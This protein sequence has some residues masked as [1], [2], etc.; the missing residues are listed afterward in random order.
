MSIIG[1]IIAWVKEVVTDIR[2]DVTPA[3]RQERDHEANKKLGKQRIASAAK[4]RNLPYDQNSIVDT[5][6]VLQ[7]AVGEGFSSDEQF[8]RQLAADFGMHDY[9]PKKADDNVQLLDFVYVTIGQGGIKNPD[10][11]SLDRPNP[12]RHKDKPL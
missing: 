3:D 12:D 2:D 9:D 8:R 11:H 1:N 5:L 6:K 10:A 7:A 4:A